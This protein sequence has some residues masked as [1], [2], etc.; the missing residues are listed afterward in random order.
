MKLT[1][2]CVVGILMYKEGFYCPLL[3]FRHDWANLASQWDRG[4]ACRAL[5]I[6]MGLQSITLRQDT[7]NIQGESQCQSLHH[8]TGACVLM[9]AAFGICSWS[10]RDAYLGPEVTKGYKSMSHSRAQ[11]TV[12]LVA[13]TEYYREWR[14]RLAT[15]LVT[16]T[17]QPE[18]K[19]CA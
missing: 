10:N 17:G 19:Y 15:Y 8:Q 5:C 11:R 7:L 4:V 3:G 16:G 1:L 6:C 18:G 13:L 9:V 14:E 12:P 2:V